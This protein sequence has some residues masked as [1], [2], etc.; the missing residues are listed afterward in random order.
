MFKNLR[1]TGQYRMKF[2]LG[3]STALKK[4][5]SCQLTF[6]DRYL[7]NPLSTFNKKN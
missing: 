3:T 6:C 7:S 4:R 1:E 2:D 5:L